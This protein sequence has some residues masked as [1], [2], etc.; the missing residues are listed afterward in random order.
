MNLTAFFEVS[1]VIQLHAASAILSLIIGLIQIFGPKGNLPHRALGYAFVGLMVTAATTAIFIR[2]L[3]DGNFSLI[4]LFV[5]L[6]FVSLVGLVRYAVTNRGKEHGT[7]AMRLML[8]ALVIPGVF[9]FMPGR[10][11]WVVVAG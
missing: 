11:M 6:T 5:P 2:Q 1:W 8:G 10:L 9:A 7:N 3:N 4:H